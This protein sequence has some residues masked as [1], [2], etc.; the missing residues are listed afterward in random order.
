MPAVGFGTCCRK[1]AKG[2]ALVKAATAYL[3][4]GG[5]LIDTAIGYNNHKEIGEALR[6]SGVPRDQVWITSKV[7]PEQVASDSP[8]ASTAAI[9][10]RSLAQ[11]GATSFDLLLI[12][13]PCSDTAKLLEMWRGLIDGKAKGHA[14]QI[15]VS[16]LDAAHI[17][18]LEQASGVR[19]A[20]NEIE[21]HPF[22]P[23]TT[24]ELV[25]WCQAR[26]IA[27]IVYGS[28]GSSRNRLGPAAAGI[29][30]VAR[31]HGVTPQQVLLRWALD[32]RVAVI[33]GSNDPAHIA[34]NLQLC[35]SPGPQL[36][37]PLVSRHSP[38]VAPLPAS[39]NLSAADLARID[40]DRK[41]P[42]FRRWSNLPSE[43]A[44]AAAAMGGRAAHAKV[45]P[46]PKAKSPKVR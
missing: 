41:P 8:R 45:K 21:Y 37:P 27:V 22:S 29:A 30:S 44:E 20:A 26:G 3:Q 33:P 17:E 14:R 25:R 5:R 11:L 24:R 1:G 13:N 32:Q 39:F 12:H 43:A 23:P 2:E 7:D 28:L 42:S 31:R 10:S 38:R 16:N 19:P 6:R 46:K 34:Q 4:L 35:S 15:G 9:I 40:A 36:C 18:R